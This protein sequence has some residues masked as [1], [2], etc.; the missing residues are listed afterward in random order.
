M[1]FYRGDLQSGIALAVQQEKLVACL[2]VKENHHESTKWEE[3]L[4][5]T[6]V[7]AGG[8]DADTR[9]S[10]GQFLSSKA[11]VLRLIAGSKEAG[12]LSAYA[13]I[14]QVPKLVVISKGEVLL[15]IGSES[16]DEDIEKATSKLLE[17]FETPEPA[18]SIEV[19]GASATSSSQDT[20]VTPQPIQ[21]KCQP[22]LS[23]AERQETERETRRAIAR[24]RRV[25]EERSAAGED[26]T[27]PWR[28][29]WVE[30]QRVRQR[31]ARLEKEAIRKAIADD[32]ERRLQRRGSSQVPLERSTSK[33]KM[34]SSSSAP[35]PARGC[36]L[37]IRLFDGTSIKSKF[38]AEAT[39]STAVRTFVSNNSTTDTPY[40]FRMMDPSKP[41]RTIEI[42]EENQTLQELGLCPGAT[43]V[44]VAVKDFTDAYA[45]QGASG[46]MHQGINLGYNV[47]YGAFSLVGGILGKVTGYPATSEETEGPYIAGTGD[48]TNH[49]MTRKEEK[50]PASY[51]APST[52]IKVT[53]L[54]DQKAKQPAE[55]YNGNT[56]NV[57]PRPDE[58][59]D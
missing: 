31:E 45:A 3:Q 55:F 42:S 23:E 28:R 37:Q 21:R 17:T 18:V 56:T 51:S 39:L 41:A 10:F 20:S 12:F 4:F 29:T 35:T 46:V 47:V 6:E 48:N 53:T 54:A 14:E 19:Q 59:R 34:A 9:P 44:L 8:E 26:I 32:R 11:V 52:G 38:E 43:L 5:D 24:A 30:Q 7:K 2:V 50:R 13:S 36:S 1:F 16:T 49:L 57:E 27:P 15:E 40:N 33:T 22:A 25:Q 58:K